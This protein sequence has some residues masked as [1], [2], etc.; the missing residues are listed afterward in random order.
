MSYKELLVLI[1]DRIEKKIEP[2]LTEEEAEEYLGKSVVEQLYKIMDY[3]TNSRYKLYTH[4]FTHDDGKNI[5]LDGFNWSSERISK[6]VFIKETGIEYPESL[7]TGIGENDDGFIENSIV[8]PQEYHGISWDQDLSNRF[9]KGNIS[10]ADFLL[11]FVAH[12]GDKPCA[13]ILMAIIPDGDK[14][15]FSNRYSVSF[16]PDDESLEFWKY[17]INESELFIGYL[18]I[19]NKKIV[20]NPK[21]DSKKLIDKDDRTM[22]YDDTYDLPTELYEARKR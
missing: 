2:L 12:Y 11:R 15:F 18:D 6:D 1:A 16:D 4:G 19:E 3:T 14:S 8:K 7:L 13:N 21:F 17:E 10:I 9:L 22:A 5:L 20:Y